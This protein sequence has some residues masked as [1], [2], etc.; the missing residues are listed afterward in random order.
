MAIY[1]GNIKGDGLKVALVVSRF[2]GSV[3]DQLVQGATDELIRHGVADE[4]IDIYRVPGAFELP[5]VARRTAESGKYSA[6]VC[7]GAVIRGA[8]PHFEYVASEAAKGIAAV[9]QAASCPVV[10]GVL[11]CDTLDQAWERSGGKSGNKGADAARAAM[12]LVDL[13]QQL[14]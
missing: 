5:P 7:L 12:E 8:T 2:N 13:Y 10:F 4:A 9:A 3:T 14:G 1:E 6:V 11:T